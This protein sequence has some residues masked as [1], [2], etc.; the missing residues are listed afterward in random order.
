MKKIIFL[1]LV[2]LNLTALYYGATRFFVTFA[3]VPMQMAAVP[4]ELGHLHHKG[5]EDMRDFLFPGFRWLAGTMLINFA[6]AGIA[7]FGKWRN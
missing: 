5:M 6:A 7:V 3:D 4:A 1:F 2:L